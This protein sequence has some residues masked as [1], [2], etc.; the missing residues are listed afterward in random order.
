MTYQPT[1]PRGPVGGMFSSPGPVYKLPNLTGQKDHDIRSIHEKAPAYPFGYRIAEKRET[2]GPGPCYNFQNQKVYRTGKDG[3]PHYSLYSRSRD[4]Q[5]FVNPAANRYYPENTFGI[6]MPSAPKY[7]FR[8]KLDTYSTD[9]TPGKLA[10]II[11]CLIVELNKFVII[12]LQENE[13]RTSFKLIS[14]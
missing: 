4:K 7:S 6:S 14:K 1:I 5:E 12:F 11:L 3:T 10:D 8:P 9:N 13:S 2:V